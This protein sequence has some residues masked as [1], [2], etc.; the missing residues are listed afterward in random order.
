MTWCIARFHSVDN[1]R[2]MCGPLDRHGGFLNG[3]IS[4]N[5]LRFHDYDTAYEYMRQHFPDNA[6][7]DHEVVELESIT[8]T[9]TYYRFYD[10][11]SRVVFRGSYD[12]AV[13]A[14]YICR[15]KHAEAK[16]MVKVWIDVERDP[17]AATHR[18]HVLDVL[19]EVA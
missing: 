15:G 18:G 8:F 6:V 19:E 4:D 10:G 1:D 2:S 7:T 17:V 16:P 12:D 9:V 14:F 13:V 3:Y 5:I 11:K